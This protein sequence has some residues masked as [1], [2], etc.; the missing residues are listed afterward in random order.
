VGVTRSKRWRG[1]VRSVMMGTSRGPAIEER[2]MFEVQLTNQ[3]PAQLA[4]FD[5]TTIAPNG[6]TWHYAGGPQG[7]VT[8]ID[9]P[10][11][12]FGFVDIG[13]AHIGGD[14]TEEWGVLFCFQEMSVVGRYN[15][16]GTVNITVDQFLQF[17]LEGM[18]FRQ[19]QLNGLVIATP[20][21]TQ[22]AAV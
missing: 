7:Q 9:T 18:D 12:R 1:G 15:G 6:G 16:G 14:S 3:S 19:V 20:P 10:F 2:S 11:G 13:D 17:N 22:V 8:W 5:G 21:T 4:V